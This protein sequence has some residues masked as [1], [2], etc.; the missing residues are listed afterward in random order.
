[1]LFAL[2]RSESNLVQ[3]Y[4][5]GMVRPSATSWQI[6]GRFEA[7]KFASPSAYKAASDPILSALLH[8][9]GIR[10]RSGAAT[11]PVYMTAINVLA[12]VYCRRFE[13]VFAMC[14]LG[15]RLGS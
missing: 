4:Q 14:S 9:V 2:A 10:G 13:L 1:M 6:H 5:L 11:L 3:I 15:C 8:F 7:Q 12:T